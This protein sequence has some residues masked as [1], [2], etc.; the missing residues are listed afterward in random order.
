MWASLIA[1]VAAAAN[2]LTWYITK[3]KSA[4]E[5]AYV[6]A[7]TDKYNILFAKYTAIVKERNE[8]RKGLAEAEKRLYEEAD[9][10]TIIDTI[11]ELPKIGGDPVGDN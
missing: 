3:K 5:R 8:L 11:N 6:K 1:I 4:P 9:L 2:I 7:L 10:A